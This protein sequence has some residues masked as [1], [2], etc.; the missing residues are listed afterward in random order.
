MALF[1]FFGRRKPF[2]RGSYCD[3]DTRSDVQYYEGDDIDEQVG[4]AHDRDDEVIYSDDEFH[5]E[6]EHQRFDDDMR[7]LEQGPGLW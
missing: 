2:V 5:S 7:Q 6:C 1:S 4:N 3:T